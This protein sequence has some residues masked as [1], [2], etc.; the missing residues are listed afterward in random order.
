MYI[1]LIVILIISVLED[2][3]TKYDCALT[4][5]IYLRGPVTLYS[6]VPAVGMEG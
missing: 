1:R 5:M 2:V 4:P 3:G 6:V